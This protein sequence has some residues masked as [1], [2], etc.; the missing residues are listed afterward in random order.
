[1][2]GGPGKVVIKDIPSGMA[3][4]IYKSILNKKSIT[5]KELSSRID[6]HVDYITN[7]LSNITISLI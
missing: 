3:R 1:M 6:I 7:S 5:E 2:Q 4:G